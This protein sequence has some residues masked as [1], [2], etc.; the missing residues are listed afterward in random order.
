MSPAKFMVDGAAKKDGPW[1]CMCGTCFKRVNGE[2]GWGRGQLYER[3]DSGWL[4]VGGAGS[5]DDEDRSGAV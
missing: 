1:G 5:G 2:I 4:L 3:T